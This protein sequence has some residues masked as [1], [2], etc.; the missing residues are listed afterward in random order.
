M[1]PASPP[2]QLV[3]GTTKNAH[4]MH[5]RVSSVLA[6]NDG[7]CVCPS[8]CAMLNECMP[9]VQAWVQAWMCGHPL[10]H[11]SDVRP[12]RHAAQTPRFKRVFNVSGDVRHRGYPDPTRLDVHVMAGCVHSLRCHTRSRTCNSGYRSELNATSSSSRLS[13]A[14][15]HW[16]TPAS[17]P[18][19]TM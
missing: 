13:G 16:Q 8:R 6:L 7:N 11:M 19:W 18:P 9:W 10:P 15:S 14:S 3:P 2:S 12:D 1:W 5:S 4:R 17:S